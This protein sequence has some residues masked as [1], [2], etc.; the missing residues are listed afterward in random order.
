[1]S[2]AVVRDNLRAGISLALIRIGQ[3]EMKIAADTPATETEFFRR[4]VMLD[5]KVGTV[6]KDDPAGE[7][8]WAC[9]WAR[10]P[11]V[12]T[13]RDMSAEGCGAT[14]LDRRHHLELLEADMAAENIRDLQWSLLAIGL[15]LPFCCRF[16]RPSFER[17]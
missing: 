14:V 4:A 12:L 13:A 5:T 2:R 10:P 7:H 1:V 9:P 11:R 15:F 8:G 6:E 3:V 16:W 17:R